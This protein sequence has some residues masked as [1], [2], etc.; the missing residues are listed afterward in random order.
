MRARPTTTGSVLL[1][2]V[3]AVVLAGC[4]GAPAAPGGADTA[5]AGS[6]PASPSASAPSPGTSDPTGGPT[7][8][9]TAGPSGSSQ[10]A[11]PTARPTHPPNDPHA[12]TPAP[13]K[14]TTKLATITLK[15][16]P[17]Q[18]VATLRVIKDGGP[19]PYP[20]DG[21][22][23]DNREKRLPRK[24]S[25]FYHEY[26]VTTPGAGDRGPRRIVTGA[27]GSRVWTTDH[28]RTF[29]EIIAPWS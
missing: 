3:L 28:Y 14:A 15:A 26:T 16:L 21:L 1:A 13:P 20:N 12:D 23:F 17:K 22:I 4:S 11:G 24:D 2:G 6:S 5:P 18:A 19:F 7:K 27:D 29:R 9:P 25:G 10:A 8:G